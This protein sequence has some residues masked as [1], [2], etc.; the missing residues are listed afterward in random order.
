MTKYT[1]SEDIK[2][3]YQELYN[4]TFTKSQLHEVY[5]DIVDKEEYSNF[6]CW[7]YDML[8]MSLIIEADTEITKELQ[9]LDSIEEIRQK[10]IEKPEQYPVDYTI[11][12]ISA[13][14]AEYAGYK[15]R[16]DWTDELKKNPES[17]YAQRL[18]ENRFHL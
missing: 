5:R 3:S 8:K 12:L 17:K 15:S 6:E 1:F 14:V 18:S 11:R 10:A 13:I 7:F 16:T 9:L 2:E 4:R